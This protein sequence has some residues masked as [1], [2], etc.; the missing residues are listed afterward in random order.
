MNGLAEKMNRKIMERVRNVLSHTKL[1][2]SYW[3]EGMYTIV[4]PINRLPSMPL[5]GIVPQRVWIGKHISYQHRRVFGCLGY[6]HVAKDQRLK[7]DNKSKPC[8]FMGYSEDEF[9]H[10]PW[11]L[12]EKKVV[13]SRDIVFMV[14]EAKAVN[15]EVLTTIL[16]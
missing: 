16:S 5:K 3:V 14:L 2:K 10:R 9:G 13:R 1:P 15:A 12:V 8:I 7:V 6:M 11:D 4:Y